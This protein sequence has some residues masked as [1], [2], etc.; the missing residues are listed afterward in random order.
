MV[1]GKDYLIVIDIE[2]QNA[3]TVTQMSDLDH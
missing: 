2:S 3:T 1:A